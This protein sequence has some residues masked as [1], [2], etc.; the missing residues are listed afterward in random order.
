M[1]MKPAYGLAPYGEPATHGNQYYRLSC[2]LPLDAL[3]V[4]F[5]PNGSYVFLVQS[6][7]A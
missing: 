7:L 6:E 1:N 2:K 5:V 3:V 4:S